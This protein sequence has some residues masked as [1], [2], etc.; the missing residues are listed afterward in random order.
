MAVLSRLQLMPLLSRLHAAASG[1]LS[2]MRE[3]SLDEFEKEAAVRQA[4]FV[5]LG[6]LARIM[7][8]LSIACTVTLTIV[9]VASYAGLCELLNLQRAA[10][11]PWFIA[12]SVVLMTCGVARRK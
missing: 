9:V 6:T 3:T 12:G 10:E 11:N 8:A 5:L 4:T 1:A 2:I 7:I